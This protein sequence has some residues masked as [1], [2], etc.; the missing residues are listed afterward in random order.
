[1][2]AS[3][4]KICAVLRSLSL[5]RAAA[6]LPKRSG[7]WPREADG[8]ARGAFCKAPP[9]ARLNLRFAGFWLLAAGRARRRRR[10]RRRGRGRRAAGVGGGG[11]G[12]RGRNA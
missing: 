11:G 9:G 1:M 7:G 8:V 3:S 12:G 10:R 5:L 6:A 4:P 2:F